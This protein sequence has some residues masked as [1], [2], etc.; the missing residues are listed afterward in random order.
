[1]LMTSTRRIQNPEERDT[2][3]IEDGK[4]SYA[5]VLEKST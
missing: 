4:I 3:T 1:M 5:H 2:M